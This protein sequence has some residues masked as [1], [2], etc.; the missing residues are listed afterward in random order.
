[1]DLTGPTS[2]VILELADRIKSK[3]G[4]EGGRP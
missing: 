2:V 3:A 1:M 4:F